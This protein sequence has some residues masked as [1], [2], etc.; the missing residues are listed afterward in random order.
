MYKYHNAQWKLIPLGNN[1][2]G[3]E[4]YAVFWETLAIRI[5]QSTWKGITSD[6]LKQLSWL[7]YGIKKSTRVSTWAVLTSVC[8][9]LTSK[10]LFIAILIFSRAWSD[11]STWSKMNEIQQ[12]MIKTS[13]TTYHRSNVQSKCEPLPNSSGVSKAHIS[14]RVR[15]FS[16]F[17]LFPLQNMA[18][19]AEFR[20]GTLQLLCWGIFQSSTV[21]HSSH[22]LSHE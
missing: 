20:N 19:D 16:L 21:P 12:E 3:F 10:I 1:L 8:T 11:V 6:M 2:W 14:L 4:T 18:S 15:G 9:R 13:M 17:S 5:N 7:F 22:K